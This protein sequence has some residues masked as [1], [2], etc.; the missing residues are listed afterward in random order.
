MQR[1]SGYPG[2]YVCIIP[3]LILNTS[4]RIRREGTEHPRAYVVWARPDVSA[5]VVQDFVSA[6]TAKYKHLTG[7]VVF[8]ETIPKSTSGKILRKNLRE[9]AKTELQADSLKAKL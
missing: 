1:L 6:R 8:L 5:Q 7:G 9:I 3:L 4:T 2:K